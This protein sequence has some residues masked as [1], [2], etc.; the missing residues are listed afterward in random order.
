MMPTAVYIALVDAGGHELP[1]T[2]KLADFVLDSRGRFSNRD[3][4]QFG[5]FAGVVE[6]VGVAVNL[7]A[8]LALTF[9]LDSRKHV[10]TGDQIQFLPGA[11]SVDM[12]AAASV[13][14]NALMEPQ[15][16]TLTEWRAARNDASY[17]EE[18]LWAGAFVAS[19]Q[20][21]RTL[22]TGEKE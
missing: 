16:S 2:R 5:M 4:I 7:I 19:S 1:V 13:I 17:T 8:P 12:G 11:L 3:A 21:T 14:F 6:G 20:L 15:E 9:A 22:L 10:E 18:E